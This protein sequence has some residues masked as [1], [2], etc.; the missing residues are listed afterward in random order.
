MGTGRMPLR[1]EGIGVAESGRADARRGQ[2]TRRRPRVLILVGFRERKDRRVSGVVV[3][4]LVC[5]QQ[6]QREPGG[7]MARGQNEKIDVIKGVPLFSH[8]SKKQLSEV[9]RLADEV[10][11]PEGKELIREGAAGREFFALLEGSVDVRRNDRRVNTL[12]PGDFFGEIALVARSPR[13]ATVVATTPVRVLVITAQ[14]FRG[15]L[16]N[17]PTITMNVLTALGERLPATI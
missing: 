3:R 6:R 12:G 5:G 13:T 16:H 11:L 1:W 8:L 4:L 7:V 15:L 14:G 17:Q 9:A 2:S 10:D